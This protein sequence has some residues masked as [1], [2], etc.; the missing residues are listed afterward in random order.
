MPFQ[1]TYHSVA[2]PDI[3]SKDV[4]DIMA[5][6][7]KNNSELGV[8]GCLL[9]HNKFFLQ[10]LEGEKQVVQE[11]F[12]KIKLD[13]RNDQVTLL[14]TD[15]SESRIFEEWSMAYYHVPEKAGLNPEEEKV[16]Q[17]LLQISDTSQKPN[18]T[19]KVFWYNVRQILLSEGYYRSSLSITPSD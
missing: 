5:I 14:S 12:E 16:K 13:D 15:E 9:Y 3:T 7:T 4:E 2:K 6:A 19:L 17:E 18:F 10:I 1:L 8:T 11:L